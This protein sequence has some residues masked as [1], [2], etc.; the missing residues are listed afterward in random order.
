METILGQSGSIVTTTMIAMASRRVTALAYQASSRLLAVGDEMGDVRIIGPSGA[1]REISPVA[2]RAETRAS[3][4]SDGRRLRESIRGLCFAEDV[5]V[6]VD[7]SG[8]IVAQ[9]RR[10]AAVKWR[11][12]IPLLCP[13]EESVELKPRIFSFGK[14]KPRSGTTELV[15]VEKAQGAPDLRIK[16]A[17]TLPADVFFS[18]V[19]TVV[20][21][22]SYRIV[23][24]IVDNAPDGVATGELIVSMEKGSDLHAYFNAIVK[25]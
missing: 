10:G 19:E 7:R 15:M 6:S 3:G 1:D 11:A 8:A 25:R 21:G 9:E 5:V 24:G 14:V 22:M 18:R 20:E 12:S 2:V 13:P 17:R 4:P 23:V 16:S